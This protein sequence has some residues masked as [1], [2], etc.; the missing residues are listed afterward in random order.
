MLLS[1]LSLAYAYNRQP[2]YFFP[3]FPLAALTRARGTIATFTLGLIWASR[4]ACRG[5]ACRGAAKLICKHAK[6]R[7]ASLVEF[8]C[9]MQ[10]S[11]GQKTPHR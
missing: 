2:L 5:E 4:A 8:Y 7:S 6:V 11:N 10:N 9:K 3:I 1:Q